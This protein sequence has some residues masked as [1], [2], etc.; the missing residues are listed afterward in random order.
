ME[1]A[2]GPGSAER[3]S[4]RRRRR[5]SRPPAAAPPGPSLPR[6]CPGPFHP[7]IKLFFFF[8][9]SWEDPEWP[10]GGGIAGTNSGGG[11]GRAN[12]RAGE[13]RRRG[14]LRRDGRAGA[15][16]GGADGGGGSGGGGESG[17]RAGL[18]PRGRAGRKE[19]PSVQVTP[20]GRC[21]GVRGGGNGVWHPRR[22][23]TVPPTQS[24]G[25]RRERWV[26]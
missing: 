8:Q 22:P 1:K 14:L 11:R 18:W 21:A 23:A 20:S 4:R 16:P 24:P 15:V 5:P 9:T 17:R 10:M 12:G 6:R 13:A 2:L 25:A 3:E 7:P 26:H 19:G